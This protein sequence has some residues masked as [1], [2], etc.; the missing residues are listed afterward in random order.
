MNIKYIGIDV[1][2]D[3]ISIAVMNGEGKLVME[4]TIETK[5]PKTSYLRSALPPN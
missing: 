1:H 5:L 4:S 2:E 3:A